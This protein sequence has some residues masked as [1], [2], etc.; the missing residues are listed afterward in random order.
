MHK[1]PN[2][3]VVTLIAVM[4]ILAACGGGAGGSASSAG[5]G[6]QT[7]VFQIKLTDGTLKP[8]T[9]DNL[10]A[11][12]QKEI[13]AAG[14]AQNGPALID[15]LTQAG[16][17]EFAQATIKGET[18]EIVLAKAELT[19]DVI[20]DYANDGTVKIASPTLP[21]PSPVRR[22]STIELQ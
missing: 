6:N 2:A 14:K 13:M 1:L 20:L 9:L 12:P 3:R 18:G 17:T 19:P 11:L 15:V 7:A 22:V 4:F 10:K 5:S 16:A 8:V 21:M